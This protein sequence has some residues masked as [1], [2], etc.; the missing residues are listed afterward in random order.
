MA[1]NAESIDMTIDINV[2][3][4][5]SQT[6]HISTSNQ[7][8]VQNLKEDIARLIGIPMEQQRLIYCGKVLK[9]DQVISSYNYQMK[10]ARHPVLVHPAAQVLA[11]ARVLKESHPV[12]NGQ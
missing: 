11:I 1:Q 7:R 2:K 5:D 8:R 12:L 6:H 9:D 4:M 10:I 3:T